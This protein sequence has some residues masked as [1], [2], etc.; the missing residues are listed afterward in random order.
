MGT[1]KGLETGKSNITRREGLGPS[2][3]HPINIMCALGSVFL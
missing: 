3:K 2:G 1:N